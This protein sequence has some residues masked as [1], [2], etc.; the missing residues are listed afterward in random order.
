MSLNWR[1]IA[2]HDEIPSGRDENGK[3]R[4]FL[5]IHH[6]TA[7]TSDVYMIWKDAS[8]EIPRW[9]HS[10]DKPITHIAEFN[11][12]EEKQ[13]TNY[14]DLGMLSLDDWAKLIG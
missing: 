5:A 9:G 13:V 1:K 2:S 6:S 3:L 4:Y 7:Y 10:L 14:P 11:L 12:P 8:G